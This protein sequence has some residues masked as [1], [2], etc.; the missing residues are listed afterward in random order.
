MHTGDIGEWTS[1][2]ALRII[3][4]KKNI[5]KLSQVSFRVDLRPRH[6]DLQMAFS[7]LL[8]TLCHNDTNCGILFTI[9]L[10]LIQIHDK[11]TSGNQDQVH[12]KFPR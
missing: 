12:V 1:D 5:F 9:K 10:Y 7:M 4:R 3:D 11:N 2:W 8:M 6:G